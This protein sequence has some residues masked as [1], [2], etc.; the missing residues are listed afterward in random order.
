MV[1][2]ELPLSP[3][4]PRPG[5][6]YGVPGTPAGTPATGNNRVNEMRFAGGQDNAVVLVA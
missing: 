3:E 1:S 2:P 5:I 6:K 4:L